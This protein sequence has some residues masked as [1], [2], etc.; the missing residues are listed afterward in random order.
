MKRFKT[1]DSNILE[2][3]LFRNLQWEAERTLKARYSAG[4][5]L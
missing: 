5:I 4:R 1:V 3:F 2:C